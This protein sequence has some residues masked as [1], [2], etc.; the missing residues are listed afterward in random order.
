M[1]LHKYQMSIWDI[2]SVMHWK[3]MLTWLLACMTKN[4]PNCIYKNFQIQSFLSGSSNKIAVIV[5]NFFW[6]KFLIWGWSFE[7]FQYFILGWLS[8]V[9]HFQ[10]NMH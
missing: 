4:E 2:T 5:C 9:A 7:Y 1:L 8:T 6:Q 10:T 3:Q